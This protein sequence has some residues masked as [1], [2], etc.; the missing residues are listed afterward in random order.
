MKVWL[1]PAL[2]VLMVCC[3]TKT[4]AATPTP[5]SAY[6]DL[7]T[8]EQV[9][10]SPSG[11]SIAI[12]TRINERRS[13]GILDP[14]KGWRIIAPVG[15]I[16]VRGL[17]WAGEDLVLISKSDSVALGEN[18][19]AARY[20]LPDV[21]VLPL[22]DGKVHPVFSKASAVASV[23]QGSYGSRQ[24]GGSWVGFFGGI[25]LNVQ[26]DTNSKGNVALT[27]DLMQV[28]LL[29]GTARSV[30][31][32]AAQDHKRNWLVDGE[33]KIGAT[34]DLNKL[35]GKW[36]I[37]NEA[38]LILASGVSPLGDVGM[39]SFGKDGTS[40]IYMVDNL[41]NRRTFEVPLT[42]GPPTEPFTA[43]DVVLL[44]TDDTNNRLLGYV[45]R[46]D[47]NKPIFFN[48]ANQAAYV[49]TVRAFP[50]RRAIPVAW[51]PDFRKLVVHT[52]GNNDSGTWYLVDVA[53]RKA[54]P[55]GFDRPTIAADAIGPISAVEYK[56]ADG[57]A[58]NGILTLPP[59]RS[60]KNLPVVII[61]RDNPAGHD[62]ATF[63]WQAQAFASRGYAVFQPNYR[64]S[65]GMG[66]ALRLAG[67]G[68]L[69]RK[70]QTDISDG[71]AELAR[72]GFVDPKRACILGT[73]LGGYAAL[74]GVTLQQGVY[75]CAVGVAP[76]ADLSQ[77]HSTSYRETGFDP[78]VLR[79]LRE[80]LGPAEDY[81]A[82]SPRRHAARADAPILMIHGKEDVCVPFRQSQSMADALKD[83]GKPYELV[84]LKEED[85]WLSR[86]DTR[87]Q[88]L[89]AAVAFVQ[90]YNPAE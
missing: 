24:M 67:K 89:E 72:R 83:A 71:L 47:P 12:L 54:S 90:K 7:P 62:D 80:T 1:R 57:L 30:A 69:G 35:S 46:V 8:V 22:A 31:K 13:V 21:V 11:K 68:E 58:M 29:N 87:Q 74:A 17:S 64:G 4:V 81:T 33:G 16:K 55:I 27:P 45:P 56:A 70:I 53:A 9:A 39:I 25:R 23:V 77:Y 14:D 18:F 36:T 60:P 59:G 78:M 51:T 61:P 10:I 5:L 49:K 86:A 32:A 48:P 37:E 19:T 3:T 26:R 34:F 44:L 88:M 20:E 85:H 2:T 40:V 84:I 6:G 79:W 76:I 66:E 41:G 82:I 42:G 65:S 73:G 38:G 15:E 52:S 50:G 43:D 75:R 28:D 63:D